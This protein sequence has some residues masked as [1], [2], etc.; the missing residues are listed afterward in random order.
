VSSNPAVTIGVSATDTA[1]EVLDQV[2]RKV[3]VLNTDIETT[4]TSA[5]DKVNTATNNIKTNWASLA[6]KATGMVAGVVG[7]ATS[8]DVLERAQ[9]KS[10]QAN[11]TLQKSQEALEKLQNSGKATAQELADAQEKV[12]INQDKANLA[13][14]H[15]SDTYMNFLANVPA[16]LL[17]FGTSAIAM[18]GML[19]A[20]TSL[21]TAATEAFRIESIMAFITNP[22]GLAI[23]GIT[24]LVALLYFNVGGLRD[25]VYAVGQAIYDFITTKLGPLSDMLRGLIGWVSSLTGAKQQDKK[26]ADDLAESHAELSKTI[27]ITNEKVATHADHLQ[28]VNDKLTESIRNN[29]SFLESHNALASGL[30]KTSEQVNLL[31]NYLKKQDDETERSKQDNFD[32]VAS[33]YTL[34]TALSMTN[35]QLTSAAETIKTVESQTVNA[36]SKIDSMKSSLDNLASS[37]S[38][39]NGL[40][41]TTDQVMAA[42]FGGNSD[43][44][45]SAAAGRLGGV[46]TTAGRV[47]DSGG[48]LYEDV[49][50]FGTR[51]GTPHTLHEGENIVPKGGSNGN[52]DTHIHIEL[53]GAEIAHIIIDK[54]Q[55]TMHA[56]SRG[57]YG[58]VRSY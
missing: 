56:T 44:M 50:G 37:L 28:K 30:V 19:A 47:L 46:F 5:S 49:I 2:D 12:S 58:P 23:I 21:T 26:A 55:N 6:E 52:G 48:T 36:T 16:Q 27:D 1:S 18:H 45:A 13:Q 15:A 54:Q 22:V 14:G 11:L 34:Q 4:S 57:L 7:F 29:V 40:G 8:F 42:G 10:D 51:T 41:I 38:Q 31:A 9:V 20:N 3:S 25:M 35:D 17:S 43:I 32:L 53:G 24:T 39:I 33:H